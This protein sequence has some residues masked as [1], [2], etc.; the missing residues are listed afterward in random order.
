MKL[1]KCDVSFSF[2]NRFLERHQEISLKPMLQVD[3]AAFENCTVEVV[4][5]YFAKLSDLL[6]QHNYQQKYVFNYDETTVEVGNK[7]ALVLVPSDLKFATKAQP[8][9]MFHITLGLFVCAD[10]EHFKPPIVL[11]L[12]EFPLDLFKNVNDF[13]WAGSETRWIN[14]DIFNQAIKKILL[15]R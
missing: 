14:T 3:I 9:V 8:F 6:S 13:T 11:P 15:V 1:S 7:S 2:L 12:V 10:G 5:D 4:N